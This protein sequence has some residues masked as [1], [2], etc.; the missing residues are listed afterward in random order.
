MSRCNVSTP[1]RPARTVTT[2]TAADRF[3]FTGLNPATYT[4]TVQGAQIR[5]VTIQYT[6]P[7]SN[8]P[9]QPLD[10]PVTLIQNTISGSVLGLQ[11]NTT[12]P[13]GLNGIPVELGTLDPT[14]GHFVISKNV[15][16]GDLITTTAINSANVNGSFVFT[17][18]PDGTYVARI[19]L[20]ASGNNLN[21]SAVD[22][23]AAGVTPQSITVVGGQSGQF[24]PVTLQRASH[25]V[26]L[27]IATTAAGDDV[28]G[29]A[30]TLTNFHDSSWTFSATGAY[31]ST[32]KINSWT[33]DAVPADSHN[34]KLSVT[35]PTGHLGTIVPG[36]A[37]AGPALTCTVATSVTAQGS[38]VS[39]AAT[40]V[41]VPGPGGDISLDY[42][43]D[44]FQV[45]LE[46][47]AHHL[48]TDPNVIP[49]SPSI[50]L[51]DGTDD[52]Y[53]NNAFP[54]AAVAD[55]SNRHIL[56]SPPAKPTRS[57]SAP[58]AGTTA[59]PANWQLTPNSFCSGSPPAGTSSSLNQGAPF[60]LK[61]AGHPATTQ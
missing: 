37:S 45:Q 2:Q 19:N 23:A 13:T 39:P 28:S 10:V 56:G 14:D 32:T 48:L 5:P 16:G 36:G 44:E 1:R 57:L 50:V 60:T 46:G 18:A 31:N 52:V 30:A 35:L 27:N 9:P 20:A 51:N 7:L 43:L 34:W 15:T 26:T 25:N 38:C 40:P 33:F 3:E 11:G 54:F 8:N 47:E 12:I 17:N 24:S 53:S 6:V 49:P 21:Y 41:V 55:R 4:I 29:A 61:V 59:L 58:S 22:P 42:T